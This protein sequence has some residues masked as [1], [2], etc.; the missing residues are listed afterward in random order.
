MGKYSNSVIEWENDISEWDEKSRVWKQELKKIN[1]LET[2][3]D[4]VEYYLEW[5]GWRDD[6]GLMEILLYF[7]CTIDQADKVKQR[8]FS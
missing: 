2:K 5:R 7:M 8:I 3:Q 1:K 4:V 6:K